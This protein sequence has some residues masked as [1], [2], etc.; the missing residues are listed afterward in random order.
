MRFE[1]DLQQALEGGLSLIVSCGTVQSEAKIYYWKIVERR[2]VFG[3]LVEESNLPSVAYKLGGLKI[4]R[5]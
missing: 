4:V 5:C 3:Q 1:G 2:D